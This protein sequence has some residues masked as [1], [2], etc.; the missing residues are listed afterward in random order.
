MKLQKKLDILKT[1][2]IV[3]A[4]TIFLFVQFA[5]QHNLSFWIL[6]IYPKV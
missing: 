1:Y 3:L 5:R 6:S 2:A 4:Q